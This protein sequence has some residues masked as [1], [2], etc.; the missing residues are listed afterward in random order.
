M[1]EKNRNFRYLIPPL[2][3]MASL[4]VGAYFDNKISLKD[5]TAYLEKSDAAKLFLTAIFAGT[6]LLA[7]G[8]LISAWTVFVFRV[9]HSKSEAKVSREALSR[10]CSIIGVSTS[11]IDRR[12][13]SLKWGPRFWKHVCCNVL[14]F[15]FR[16]KNRSWETWDDYTLQIIASFHHGLF[17]PRIFKWIERRMDMAHLSWNCAMSIF[18]SF[19]VGYI[20]FNINCPP[21][22]WELWKRWCWP[23]FGFTTILALV[24]NGEKAKTDVMDMVEMLSWRDPSWEFEK[25]RRES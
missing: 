21:L 1:G 15:P 2:I 18:L 4:A 24:T 5:Y 11:F 3:F 16:A 19:I 22:S 9:F 6:T 14:V 12:N 8:F 25:N 7:L 10:I 23:V 20:F 17:P 13:N